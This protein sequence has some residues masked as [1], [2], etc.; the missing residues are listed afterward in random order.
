MP[1]DY[2]TII[3]EKPGNRVQYFAR[4]R[5]M[6]SQP[7]QILVIGR[8]DEALVEFLDR[9]G[10]ID[11]FVR[12]SVVWHKERVLSL[13][14]ATVTRNELVSSDAL[15]QGGYVLKDGVI[16][17]LREYQA[18]GYRV[19]VDRLAFRRWRFLFLVSDAID[20]D[21]VELEGVSLDLF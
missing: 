17:I 2:R 1:G 5:E 3:A 12:R 20:S 10:E 15:M 9:K 14:L 19:A 6:I 11:G 4:L 21:E 16:N 8:F 18:K 13:S 7:E